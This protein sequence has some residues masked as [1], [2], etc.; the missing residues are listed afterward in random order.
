VTRMLNLN[1][2]QLIQKL[3]TRVPNLE[4]RQRVLQ[5]IATEKGIKLESNDEISFHTPAATT[6]TAT[7]V[8]LT[9]Q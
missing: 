9:V 7:I 8:R 2:L 5:E 3:S 4:I 1:V 6:K